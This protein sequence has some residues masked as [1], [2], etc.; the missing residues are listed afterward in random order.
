MSNNYDEII[1]N[2]LNENNIDEIIEFLTTYLK[3][4]EAS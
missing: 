4:I 1:L 2:L 3:S